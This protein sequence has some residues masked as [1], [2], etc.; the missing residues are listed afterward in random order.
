MREVQG[1]KQQGGAKYHAA[2]I[3]SYSGEIVATKCNY[4][5]IRNDG[6]YRMFYRTGSYINCKKC[7]QVLAKEEREAA[8]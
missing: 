4:S 2:V 1:C 7:R 6:G 5:K 8:E 3:D